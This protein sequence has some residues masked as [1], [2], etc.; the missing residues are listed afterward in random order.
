[1]LRGA[2]MRTFPYGDGAFDLVMT[3][4]MLEHLADLRAVLNEMARVSKPGGLLIACITRRS[5]LGVRLHLMSRTHWMTP[6]R[7]EIQ[8]FKSGLEITL[9]FSFDDGMFYRRLSLACACRKPG[10]D[11][12]HMTQN[13][14]P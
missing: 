2:D 5:A 13:E 9:D 7:A 1:M 12:A 8:L 4:H 11:D 14:N 3:A 10:S 6:D